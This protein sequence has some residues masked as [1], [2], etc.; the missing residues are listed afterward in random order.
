MSNYFIIDKEILPEYIEKVIEA[1]E[2]VESKKVKGVSEAVKL[3]G[4]SRS[5]YYKYKDYVFLPSNNFGKKTT[6][7]MMLEHQKGVLS[8]ILNII[9]EKNGNILTI[10]QEI[11][12][13]NNAMITVTLDI[14]E[15]AVSIEQLIED[16]IHL[17]GVIT[18]ELIAI[19]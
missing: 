7:T 16:L 11:P 19:E 15:M 10:N 14:S 12:I 13:N 6:F 8:N 18:G 9:A 2:L 3:V 1:R 4:I 5:T 17:D